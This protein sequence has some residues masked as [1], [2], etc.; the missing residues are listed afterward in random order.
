MSKKKKEKPVKTINP[1]KPPVYPPSGIMQG[2]KVLPCKRAY[3]R[4]GNVR[5]TGYTKK[6]G[7]HVKAH[8]RTKPDGSKTNKKRRK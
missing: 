8:T 2:V 3:K 1:P 7:T 6:N 5:V 4:D